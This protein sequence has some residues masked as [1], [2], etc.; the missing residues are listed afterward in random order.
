MPGVE[1]I[2]RKITEAN[3]SAVARACALDRGYVSGVLS[4]KHDPGLSVARKVAR[5]VG[6]TVD[7]LAGYL[8]R[9]MNLNLE[10]VN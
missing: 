7:E 8:E 6:V 4:G 5:A 3:R 1:Q 9:K 2:E 10:A